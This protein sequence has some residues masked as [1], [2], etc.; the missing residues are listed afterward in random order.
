[1]ANFEMDG[2]T[3]RDELVQRVALMEAMIAEGRRSTARYGW[4]FVIVGTGVFCGVG[5]VV[6]SAVSQFCV[7][8]V[9]CDGHRCAE[10]GQGTAEAQGRD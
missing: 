4:V 7:A 8:G 9:H 5:M 1:M 6:L 10:R 2:G 3:T